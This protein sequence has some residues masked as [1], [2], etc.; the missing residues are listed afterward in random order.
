MKIDENQKKMMNICRKTMNICRKKMKTCRKM[1]K[2]E[3]NDDDRKKNI[4][5]F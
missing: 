2:I 3:R 4:I 5:M 1:M